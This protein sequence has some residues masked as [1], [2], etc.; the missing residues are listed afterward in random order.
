MAPASLFAAIAEVASTPIATFHCPSRRPAKVYPFVNS[1]DYHLANRP[2]GA[3]RNDYAAN[4]GT[5]NLGH[6]RGPETLEA[7][8]SHRWDYA[9]LDGVV[10]Q[11]SQVTMSDISDGTSQTY[12]V[13]EKY[14]GVDWYETGTDPA[15]DQCLYVGYNVDTLRWT[16]QP[17]MQD[18]PGYS[19]RWLFGSAHSASFSI[20][21]CDGSVRA[22]SYQIDGVLHLRLGK[23]NDGEVIDTIGL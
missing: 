21:L 12:L 8:D 15:D 18:A 10:F 23:R 14:L 5:I 1:T 19:D 20:T 7:A 17:P 6:D 9:D 16:S 11:R 22:I 13:G 2:T 3:A 4:A